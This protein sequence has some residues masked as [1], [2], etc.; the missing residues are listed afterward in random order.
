MTRLGSPFW[1]VMLLAAWQRE[2]GTLMNWT[3]GTESCQ[4]GHKTV[5]AGTARS[6]RVISQGWTCAWGYGD[7]MPL[8]KAYTWRS[9]TKHWRERVGQKGRESEWVSYSFCAWSISRNPSRNAQKAD[10]HGPWEEK[11]GWAWICPSAVP[12]CLACLSNYKK[13]CVRVQWGEEERKLN[14]VGQIL[15]GLVEC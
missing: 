15:I 8:T 4:E 12:P 10:K 11:M 14:Q 3:P 5:G 9:P 2:S 6:L 7:K 1:R 13:L